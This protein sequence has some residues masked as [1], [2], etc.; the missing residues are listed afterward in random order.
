M[1]EQS[2]KL[3]LLLTFLGSIAAGAA[4]ALANRSAKAQEQIADELAE[5]GGNGPEIGQIQNRCVNGER[6]REFSSLACGLN[7]RGTQSLVRFRTCTNGA[8]G[9]FGAVSATGPCDDDEVCIDGVF[10]NRNCADGGQVESHRCVRGQFIETGHECPTE[11]EDIDEPFVKCQHISSGVVFPS[12]TVNGEFSDWKWEIFNDSGRRLSVTL[13]SLDLGRGMNF[14]PVVSQSNIN[15][16]IG[17]N[18]V[19]FPSI[20]KIRSDRNQ[21]VELTVWDNQA[22]V[23]CMSVII[24][25]SSFE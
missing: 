13:I 22:Q 10:R 25:V 4:L 11:E 8:W 15:L 2:R 5:D 1:A 6:D 23:T 7:N 20:R 12:N 3:M 14:Q 18:L 16:N 17:R 19:D 21:F 24:D 9:Q